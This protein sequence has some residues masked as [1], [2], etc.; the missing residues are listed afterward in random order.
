MYPHAN[1][2][3][4]LQLHV[5]SVKTRRCGWACEW[6]VLWE[7]ASRHALCC[8]NQLFL[9]QTD[10]R[11]THRTAPC[12]TCGGCVARVCTF[13]CRWWNCETQITIQCNNT[14]S[15]WTHPQLYEDAKT[16]TEGC[17]CVSKGFRFSLLCVRSLF[18]IRS[19]NSLIILIQIWQDF[20]PFE[21][22]VMKL[23]WI[24]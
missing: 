21:F 24:Q 8:V 12:M 9:L 15:W 14:P 22:P 3:L 13:F 4:T 23:Q 17:V 19:M 1:K 11:L 16:S 18:F 6:D 5:K 10:C 7:K 2:L 20:W